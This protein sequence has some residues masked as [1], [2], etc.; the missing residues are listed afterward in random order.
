MMENPTVLTATIAFLGVIVSVSTS[1]MITFLSTRS[2]IRKLKTS[3]KNQYASAILE[4]RMNVY[5]DCYYILSHFAKHARGYINAQSPL[6]YS[7]INDFN[8]VLSEWDSRNAILLSPRSVAMISSLRF[9]LQN[10]LRNTP[11]DNNSEY[12]DNEALEKLIRA[13]GKLEM[14]LRNDIGIYE[15]E[16][17]EQRTFFMSNKEFV[18]NAFPEILQYDAQRKM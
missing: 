1:L 9:E 14:A 12:K 8:V 2:E 3:L 7:D 5:G 13:V 6:T 18:R 15:V 17:H 11:I 10:L 16:T 4:K